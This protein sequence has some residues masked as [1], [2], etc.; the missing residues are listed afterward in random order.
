MIT[1]NPQFQC[2]P[3]EQACMAKASA[4]ISINLSCLESTLL[5]L[6][7]LGVPRTFSAKLIFSWVALSCEL[8]TRIILP[9][10]RGLY[11]LLLNFPVLLSA[12]FSGLPRSL[13]VAAQLSG[14]SATPLCAIRKVADY[15]QCPITQIINDVEQDWNPYW[16]PIWLLVPILNSR[17][18]HH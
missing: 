17:K 9:W 11:F 3:W 5:P 2:I 18:F 15:T 8:G 7:K 16:P 12:H 4:V 6:V 13:C 10:G 1:T 14:S